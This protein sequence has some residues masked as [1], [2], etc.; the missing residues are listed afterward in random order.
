[1]K[2]GE[3]IIRRLILAVVVII[4]VS[5]ITFTIAR[6]IPSDPA[7]QWVGPRATPEQIAIATEKLGLDLPLHQ[8]YFRYI[9]DLFRGDL[10]VSIKSH[11]PILLDLSAF[12]PATME[13]VFF[14]MLLAVVIGIPV[15]VLAGSKRN[16][17]F[18]HVARVFSIAGTSM[19]SFWLGL[20]LILLFFSRICPDIFL[21][22]FS[23]LVIRKL[24]W[25]GFHEIS[26]W[27]N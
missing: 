3:Y 18:D 13:L 26:R 20:L 10:G 15:G 27:G 9:G 7:R 11:N 23:R 16:S 17:L 25:R 14:A 6:V 21:G 24:F 1:M 8:Q 5:I 4:S 22:H 2:R 19:P 12:L